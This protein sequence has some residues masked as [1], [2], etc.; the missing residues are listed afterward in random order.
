MKTVINVECKSFVSGRVVFECAKGNQTEGSFQGCFGAVLSDTLRAWCRGQ[1]TP[2]WSCTMPS[3]KVATW[4]RRKK[5]PAGQKHYYWKQTHKDPLKASPQS[6]IAVKRKSQ[7]KSWP[8]GKM[9]ACPRKYLQGNKQSTRQQKPLWD[10]NCSLFWGRWVIQKTLGIVVNGLFRP[11][12]GL[13]RLSPHLNASKGG[14][15]AQR[16]VYTMC[17]RVASDH[18]KHEFTTNL[19]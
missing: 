1:T 7:R 17:P 16:F 12:W 10:H 2:Q 5:Q 3:E 4:Q 8:S 18:M 14:R 11:E 13:F 9:S 15:P 6:R 19:R